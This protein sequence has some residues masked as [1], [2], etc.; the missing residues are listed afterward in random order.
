MT[1]EESAAQRAAAV[2]AERDAVQANLLE[3]DGG[4]AKQVLEGAAV[5]GQ[6]RYPPGGG[7]PGSSA[8]LWETFLAYSAVVDRV[9]DPRHREQ[10]A[11]PQ[12]PPRA[13]G[14][15]HRRL[16]AGSPAPRCR[17]PAA[18]WP[19][20]AARRLPSPPPS[21]P[22]AARSP[23]WPASPRPSRP[24]GRPSRVPLDAATAD[25]ARARPLAA[26]LGPGVQAELRDADTGAGRP[27]RRRQRGPAGPVAPG[28][29]RDRARR[30]R[31]ST[32]YTDT[33]AAAAL[34]ERTAAL[35]AGARRARPAAP[36][37]PWPDRRPR[38]GRHRRPGGPGRRR[39]RPGGKRR[40]PGSARCRRCPPRSPSRRSRAWARW[41][42]TGS[43][44]GWRPSSAAAR[45][46]LTAATAQTAALRQAP[47]DALGKRDEPRGLLRAY[48]AKAARLG[49]GRGPGPG[50]PL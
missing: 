19:R 50:R 27:A 37:G 7:V 35:A 6:T 31:P 36:A 32:G 5:T 26:G 29:R 8:T 42:P 17:S 45:P 10:A 4:F 47:P 12:G 49:G 15:A 38:G 33:A 11:R 30:Y 9:A 41:P 14:A 13:G 44:P 23:R 1:P 22:C 21:A 40:I 18:T 39:S 34:R 3:L 2:I 46:E 43:G 20:P 16:R 25:L 24:S 48:K 28:P